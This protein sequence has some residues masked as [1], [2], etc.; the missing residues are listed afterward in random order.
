MVGKC[1]YIFDNPNLFITSEKMKRRDLLP[2]LKEIGIDSKDLISK[3]EEEIQKRVAISDLNK[4]N[5]DLGKLIPKMKEKI[6]THHRMYSR[7]EDKEAEWLD[8]DIFSESDR[9]GGATY[10]TGV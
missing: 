7:F 3:L 1:Q 8:V 5:R 9:G 2:L 6:K 10:F 4:L